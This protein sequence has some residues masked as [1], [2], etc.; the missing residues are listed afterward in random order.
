V[1]ESTQTAV[2]WL[3]YNKHFKLY[4]DLLSVAFGVE[5]VT[6]QST[7]AIVTPFQP[8]DARF[9]FECLS[10]RIV[11]NRFFGSDRTPNKSFEPLSASQRKS[12]MDTQTH[13]H[14]DKMFN[15]YQL[16]PFFKGATAKTA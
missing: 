15:I 2:N 13:T 4:F 10:Y 1:T 12:A 3:C 5:S 6:C 9:F 16:H 7:I 14:T 8:E 11:E